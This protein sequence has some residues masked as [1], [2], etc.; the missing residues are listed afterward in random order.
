MKKIPVKII[1]FSDGDRMVQEVM[2][3]LIDTMQL[4]G[5]PGEQIEDFRNSYFDFVKK[6][7]TLFYGSEQSKKKKRQTLPS[8]VY[9][10]VGELFQKFNNEIKNS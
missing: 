5:D 8:S 6:V 4:E 9:Y 7:K 2:I 3:D 1:E 10:R